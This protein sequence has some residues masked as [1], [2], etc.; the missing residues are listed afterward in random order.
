MY[1]WGRPPRRRGS[2]A[3]PGHRHVPVGPLWCQQGAR[4]PRADAPRARGAASL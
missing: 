4:V 3:A 1:P 2:P